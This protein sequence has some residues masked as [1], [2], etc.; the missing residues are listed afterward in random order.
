MLPRPGPA[1]ALLGALAA[2]AS[3]AAVRADPD[4]IEQHLGRSTAVVEAAGDDAVFDSHGAGRLARRP[5]TPL[6]WSDGPR[7]VPTPRG[8]SKARA[9]RLGLGTRECAFRLLHQR[10]DPA[11]VAAAHG[12]RPSRL[13][14]P[15]DHGRWVRG[16]GYVRTTRP[17]LLHAG[18]DI[19]AEPGSVVRA[20]ADGIVAY[21]DNGVRGYGNL[22]LVVHPNGWVT[23]YA[24]NART[25]VP[26]GY[27][28]RRGERIALVGATGIARGAHLHFELRENGRAIDPVAL[29]DGGPTFVQRIAAREA[30]RGRVPPPSEVRPEDRPTEPPLPP[31]PDELSTATRSRHAAVG[32]QPTPSARMR[33]IRSPRSSDRGIRAELAP[34]RLS[35]R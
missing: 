29:F 3:A 17:D 33:S 12:R 23:L 26:A 24:H 16:F 30:A 32:S 28:V 10:P 35:I 7:R 13:L 8:A 34:R 19:A 1:V 5:S 18:V 20:A 27:R 31:H 14:W 15:V 4:P 6:R 25:T 2:L 22:V 11:W 9:E 21:S